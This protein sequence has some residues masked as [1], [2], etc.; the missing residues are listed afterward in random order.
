MRPPQTPGE[1]NR[2]GTNRQPRAV[3]CQPAT[4]RPMQLTIWQED[5]ACVQLR[6]VSKSVPKEPASSSE[7]FFLFH[8]PFPQAGVV[9]SGPP[10]GSSV[11]HLYLTLDNDPLLLPAH[12]SVCSPRGG[13]TQVLSSPQERCC[14]TGCK[15]RAE[16]TEKTRD[17]HTSRKR[18]RAGGRKHL[19]PDKCFPSFR[20]HGNRWG[21]CG[22]L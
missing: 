1:Q 3:V 7:H 22:G 17:A 21:G 20:S 15:Q 12:C 18:P 11:T 13:R 16:Q 14:P 9:L 4:Q 8:L 2:A 19:S 10:R 6:R 5:R